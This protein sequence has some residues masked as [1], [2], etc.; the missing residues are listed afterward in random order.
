MIY[1]ESLER[2]KRFKS[3]T[4]RPQ[5]WQELLPWPRRE[6]ASGRF[7]W[8][9]LT[10]GVLPDVGQAA[11][12]STRAVR[13]MIA[14]RLDCSNTAYRCTIRMLDHPATWQ[15]ARI[16][17]RFRNQTA[18]WCRQSWT[19]N[20]VMPAFRHAVW[21]ALASGLRPP[22]EP[23]RIVVMPQQDHPDRM[24]GQGSL[25][26]APIRPVHKSP[27]LTVAESWLPTAI[28]TAK[29]A[30]PRTICFRVR[31]WRPRLAACGSYAVQLNDHCGPEPTSHIGLQRA[32]ER[33]SQSRR[34][35][36]NR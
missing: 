27:S 14:S 20:P 33:R 15:R 9:R 3:S 1:K 4:A 32:R 29:F 5:P 25:V 7:P 2:A 34:A 35:A 13:A 18:K 28:S 24:C 16:L 36:R 11:R 30:V 10:D 8:K 17:P 19:R 22:C 31:G 23:L 12:R 21:C 6:P 26:V